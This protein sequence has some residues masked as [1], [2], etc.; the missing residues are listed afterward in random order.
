M[1]LFVLL[2]VLSFF[3]KVTIAQGFFKDKANVLGLDVIN[4]GIFAGE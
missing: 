1:R 3:S 2:I 4:S